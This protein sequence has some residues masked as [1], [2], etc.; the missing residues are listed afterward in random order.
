MR[1]EIPL[2]VGLDTQADP[3][4]SKATKIENVEF[5]KPGSIYKRKGRSLAMALSGKTLTDIVKWIS[6]D[7]ATWV[8]YDSNAHKIIKFTE[9]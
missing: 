3:E 8:A 2:N 7:G 6:P 1:I 4:D 9:Q 5:D